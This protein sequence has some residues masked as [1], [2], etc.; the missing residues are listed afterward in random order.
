MCLIYILRGLFEIIYNKRCEYFTCKLVFFLFTMAD[1]GKFLSN[2]IDLMTLLTMIM[3]VYQIESQM[4]LI[5][6]SIFL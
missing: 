5:T 3:K 2:R 1:V 4:F 6:V